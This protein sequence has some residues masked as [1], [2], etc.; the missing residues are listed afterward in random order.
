M[1]MQTYILASGVS[2]IPHILENIS[3]VFLLVINITCICLN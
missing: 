1:E 2:L 3:I